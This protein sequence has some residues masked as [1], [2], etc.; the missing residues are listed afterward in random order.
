MIVDLQL[1]CI[2]GKGGMWEAGE[3]AQGQDWGLPRPTRG[4]SGSPV[5]STSAGPSS[6]LWY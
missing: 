6:C 5:L 2:P 3:G 1:L 4:S